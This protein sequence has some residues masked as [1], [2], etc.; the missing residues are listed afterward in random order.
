[1][2]FSFSLQDALWHGFYVII[3]PIK[4]QALLQ[5]FKDHVKKNICPGESY[6]HIAKH[7]VYLKYIKYILNTALYAFTMEDDG[8]YISYT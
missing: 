7:S 4:L 3:M 5:A 8:L 6:G 1:M 2:W